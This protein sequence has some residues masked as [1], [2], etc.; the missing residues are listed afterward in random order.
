MNKEV[1][2]DKLTEQEVSWLEQIKEI[3]KDA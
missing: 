1:L 3:L 2:E